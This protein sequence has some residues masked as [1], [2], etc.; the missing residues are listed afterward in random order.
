MT[1][2][3]S[4]GERAGRRRPEWV[5]FALLL[6]CYGY[7]FY[8]GGQWAVESRMA[9]VRAVVE[10]G[11][12]E[13]DAY[14]RDRQG[15][16]RFGDV[17]YVPE[18]G[19]YYSDK[20]V[21][22]ALLAIPVWAAVWRGLP[23][24]GVRDP[25]V[26]QA[27]GY[28]IVNLLCN[29]LPAALVGVVFFRFLGLF[30]QDRGRRVWLTA[31]YGLGTIAWV[32]A[33]AF[34]GH[35][36]SATALFLSFALLVWMRHRGWRWW[37]AALAGLAAGFAAITDHLTASAMVMLLA[38]AVW[39]ARHAAGERAPAGVVAARAA[40]VVAAAAVMLVPQL[41]Y[42][43]YCFG[44]PLTFPYRY[45]VMPDIRAAL[46]SGTQGFSLP[47]PEALWGLTF[48]PR[49]GI[50]YN[51]P[52]LF[53]S[54]AGLVL[55]LKERRWRAEALTALGAAATV[56]VLAAGFNIWWGGAVYGARYVAPVLPLLAFP[57]I[58]AMPRAMG[59]FRVLAVVSVAVTAAAVAAARIFPED[60]PNPLVQG[61]LVELSQGTLNW[62]LGMLLG[63]SGYATL[64]PLAAA[65]GGLLAW[66]ARAV[67]EPAAP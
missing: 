61:V 31:A 53:F 52:F 27:V 66:L 28:C 4:N 26:V 37:A 22:P 38:Y 9:L 54:L 5:L 57:A 64:L 2:A 23:A 35:Q 45:E 43:A 33:I 63:L 6:V 12:I 59:A 15:E 60:V 65:A 29:A 50:F 44:G 3:E 17:A 20:G 41:L 10:R 25:A 40:P 58:R 30:T 48:G 13:V 42:N 18:R 67:R 51:S 14:V 19:H 1:G 24:L 32:Y 56:L 16:L 11:Q 47:R 55:L 49:R 8:L 34:H 21:G 36:P 39:A 46:T 62:N 7:F